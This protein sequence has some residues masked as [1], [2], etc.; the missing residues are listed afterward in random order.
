MQEATK[1]VV[2]NSIELKIHKVMILNGH[3]REIISNE[4]S[5]FI[6]N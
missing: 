4:L 5:R 1:Q 3:S 6:A 2:I